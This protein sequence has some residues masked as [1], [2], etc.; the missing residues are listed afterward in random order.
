[1]EEPL[2]I[3]DRKDLEQFEFDPYLQNNWPIAVICLPL[4]HNGRLIGVWYAEVEAVVGLRQGMM[5]LLQMLASHA[6][7]ALA[8]S[9]LYRELE[10]TSSKLLKAKEQLESLVAAR[11]EELR[12]ETKLLQQTQTR[13]VKI[14]KIATE[15]Q[16]AGGFAHEI[17]NALCP[18]AIHV[19]AMSHMEQ[20]FDVA[21]GLR[22]IFLLCKEH[23]PEKRLQETIEFMKTF[24]HREKQLNYT[25]ERVRTGIDRCIKLT[26]VIEEYTR[27]SSEQR[28][29]ELVDLGSV[30]RDVVSSVANDFG[31]ENISMDVS[32]SDKC[33]LPGRARHLQLILTNILSNSR[34]ALTGVQDRERRIGIHLAKQSNEFTVLQVTDNGAGISAE[35]LHRIFEPFFTTMPS[36][37]VGIGLNIV[38]RLMLLYDGSVQVDSTWNVGTTVTLRFFSGRGED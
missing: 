5:E 12:R 35:H 18:P 8:N 15:G 27:H 23:M 6:A 26:S 31:R 36:E 24:V 25:L 7:N 1:M 11:T 2:C 22:H 16:M 4:M 3:L 9:K 34:D 13:L 20:T 29:V 32:T 19:D 38:E 21:A 28:G 37:R 17:R 14:E 10:D 33:A 30:V